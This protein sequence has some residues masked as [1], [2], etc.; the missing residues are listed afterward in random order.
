LRE[1]K[2]NVELAEQAVEVYRKQKGLVKTKGPTLSDQQLSEI[3]TQLILARAKR[4]E[5][6][7]RP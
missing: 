7:A 1:L 4:T 6:E 3:N 2:N 5:A